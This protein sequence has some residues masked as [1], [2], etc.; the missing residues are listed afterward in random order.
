MNCKQIKNLIYFYIYNELNPALSEYISMHLEECPACFDYYSKLKNDINNNSNLEDLSAYIDNELSENESIKIKK[1]IISNKT[2]RK[3]YEKLSRLKEL[4]KSNLSR[5]E[6][7]VK[8]D[9]SKLIFKKL[10]LMEEV[11]GKNHYPQIAGIFVAIFVG[12]F[13][14]TLAIIGI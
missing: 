8:E 2:T 6:F 13:L 3:N 4:L 7:E 14:A 11:Y 12:L 1:N 10:D 9:Y 5:K